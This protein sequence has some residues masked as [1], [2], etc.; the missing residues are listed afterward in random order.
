LPYLVGSLISI[1]ALKASSAPLHLANRIS[2]ALT[3]LQEAEGVIERFENRSWSAELHRLR[4]VC[5]EAMSTD[6]AQVET[7]YCAATRIARV[8]KSISLRKRTEASY[9]STSQV[10]LYRSTMAQTIPRQF[11]FAHPK[12][13][14]PMTKAA[15]TEMII[16]NL[17]QFG[18]H[19][20]F[21]R[22]NGFSAPV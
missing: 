16:T 11:V 5:L 2:E 22:P 10:K 21:P 15:V 8:Q 4:G 17:D 6:E 1:R 18:Q 14:A 13:G 20:G 3:V 7:S 9:A 12:E 19:H